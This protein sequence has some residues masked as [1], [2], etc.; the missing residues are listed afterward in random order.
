MTITIDCRM[1]LASGIGVYLR[2]TLP[3]LLKSPHDFLLL[4]DAG[5]LQS[6]TENAHNAAVIDCAIKTFSPGELFF[7]PRG[8]LR[9][10]NSTDLYYSPFFNVPGGIKIPVY[11]TIHDI[12]FPD[13]PGLVSPLGL[14]ARMRFFRRAAAK[15]KKIFTVSRFSKS[16]IEHYLGTAKP[17]VVAGGGI[18]SAFLS[19]RVTA[20]TKNETI[21]FVGNI[22]KHKGLDCLLE[23]FLSARA[24]GLGYRLIIAGSRDNF[25]TSDNK[26]PQ[27]I[28]SLGPEAVTFTGFVSDEKLMEYISSAALLVQPSLYEGFG[29]PP[30]EAM[31]LGTRALVSDIPVFKEIYGD[32]PVAFFRAGDAA[33]LK[34]K[35]MAVLHNKKPVPLALPREL[36]RKY[37]FEKTASVILR[38]LE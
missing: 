31:V 25:R 10:I 27:K 29:L 6:F 24:E 36:S 30:L 37:T 26:V 16:R 3:W 19:H 32:F 38:E 13:M 9:K 2:E 18:R 22:K 34:E 35:M 20:L 11:T 33:D 1:L 4:G 17:V 21:I 12:I 7:F 8:I 23:A 14:F 15:S 28:D 5:K